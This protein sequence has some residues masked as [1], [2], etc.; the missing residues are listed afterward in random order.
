VLDLDA[1][2]VTN[3]VVSSGNLSQW[4]DS[5]SSANH[6]IQA[7]GGSQ[8][9][10]ATIGSN[11]AVHFGSGQFLTLS[12]PIVFSGPSTAVLVGAFDPGLPGA[13]GPFL[14]NPSSTTFFG[15]LAGTF[16]LF[17]GIPTPPASSYPRDAVPRLYGYTCGG[18]GGTSATFAGNTPIGS[19]GAGVWPGFDRIGV[20]NSGEWLMGSIGRALVWDRLLDPAEIA[21]T[22]AGLS[23]LW[24]V[25]L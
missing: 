22:L 9:T 1:Q 25:S 5:S 12:A 3:L 2:V 7:T 18:T 15:D 11:P 8:P 21:S 4:T 20:R 14:G 6:A 13:L 17:G 16:Y 23:G 10:I 19:A 24:G